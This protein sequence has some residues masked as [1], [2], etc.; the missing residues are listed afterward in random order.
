MLFQKQTNTGFSFLFQFDSSRRVSC[1][2]N[3]LLPSNQ[4]IISLNL[5]D[6]YKCKGPVRYFRSNFN[7]VRAFIY[8]SPVTFYLLPV[9]IFFSPSSVF[10]QPFTVPAVQA[11]ELSHYLCIGIIGIHVCAWDRAHPEHRPGPRHDKQGVSKAP[12][13]PL[14]CWR[15]TGILTYACLIFLY[16]KQP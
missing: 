6:P 5:I 1:L 16:I 7:A 3:F 12:R 10:H 4:L 11:R 15:P 8:S 2:T 9:F 14:I 13:D